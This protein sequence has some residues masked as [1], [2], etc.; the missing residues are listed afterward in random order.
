MCSEDTFSHGAAHYLFIYL[1]IFDKSNT[2]EAKTKTVAL[3][4]IDRKYVGSLDRFHWSSLLFVQSEKPIFNLPWF[5]QG[6]HLFGY[7]GSL[8]CLYSIALIINCS[9]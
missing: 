3:R 6:I 1:F 4:F 5:S 7:H 2:S 9:V 8:W